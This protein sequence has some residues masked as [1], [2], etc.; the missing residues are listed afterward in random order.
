MNSTSNFR[1]TS[2][3]DRRSN[4]ESGLLELRRQLPVECSR[5]ERRVW[6]EDK[7]PDLLE[8]TLAFVS[9]PG[10]SQPCCMIMAL[11][12]LVASELSVNKC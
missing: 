4:L 11:F 7:M 1:R 3:R 8:M 9:M 2:M 6:A 10:T 5:S 12:V